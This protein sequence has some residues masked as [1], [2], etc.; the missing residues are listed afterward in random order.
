[1]HYYLTNLLLDFIHCPCSLFLLLTF[2]LSFVVAI[3]VFCMILFS[4]FLFAHKLNLIFCDCPSILNACSYSWSLLMYVS[5][6]V[7]FPLDFFSRFLS[8]FQIY[9][10]C[11]WCDSEILK[12]C[13]LLM[14]FEL[15]GSV[16]GCLI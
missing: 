10:I 11:L 2:F 12:I 7:F 6:M 9:A 14:F 15:P 16:A 1:M 5:K 3:W 8:M 4:H 13:I